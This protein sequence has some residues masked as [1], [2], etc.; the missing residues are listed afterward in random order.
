MEVDLF[1]RSFSPSSFVAL[2]I[3]LSLPTIFPPPFWSL[4]L[5]LVLLITYWLKVLELCSFDALLIEARTNKVWPISMLY[6]YVRARVVSC[7]EHELY[8][9]IY[10]CIPWHA[11]LEINSGS[12][13]AKLSGWE[14]LWG[15]FP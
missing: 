7:H 3:Y 13:S 5:L 8:L 9:V 11:R 10:I 15:F 2:G 4:N 12:R 6:E 14:N 1:H